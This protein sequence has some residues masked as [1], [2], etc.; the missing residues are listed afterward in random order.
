MN[1]SISVENWDQTICKF[2]SV[3]AISQWTSCLPYLFVNTLLK[4]HSI[5]SGLTKFGYEKDKLLV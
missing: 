3:L 2:S 1:I 4:C 5:G